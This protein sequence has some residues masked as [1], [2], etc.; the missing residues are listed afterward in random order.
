M[1]A[2]YAEHGGVVSWRELGPRQRDRL[3][4][5]Y[6]KARGKGSRLTLRL[7][8]EGVED[9]D[10]A[11]AHTHLRKSVLKRA[12]GL[13]LRV[14]PDEAKMRGGRYRA[15]GCTLVFEQRAR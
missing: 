6:E 9:V 10:I 14:G 8:Q 2:M 4:E 7:A 15:S 12:P 3:A 11:N 1:L 13:E 5:L